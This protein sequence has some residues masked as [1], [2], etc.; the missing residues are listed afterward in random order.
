MS[1]H[2][3]N[4]LPM[5]DP[6]KTMKRKGLRIKALISHKIVLV[7]GRFT[8]RFIPDDPSF[9]NRQWLSVTS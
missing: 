3:S 8:F 6:S 1:S 7:S 9:Y 5:T 2:F 4:V